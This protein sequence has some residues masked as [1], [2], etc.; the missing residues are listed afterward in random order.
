MYPIRRL[1]AALLL[2]LPLI[3]SADD[4]RVAV[5]ANFTAP[6]QRIAAAF[7][8][9]TGHRAVL[10]FGATGKFYAQ[11]H[12]GAP[13]TCCCP[14]MT[15]PR[16]GW[17]T[18]ASAWPAAASPTPSAPWC[19][20]RPARGTSTRKARSWP[21]AISVTWP[22]PIQ[23]RLPMALRQW[24]RWTGWACARNCGHASCR[25]RTLRKPTSSSPAAMPSSVSWRCRR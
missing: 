25:A 13:S 11:I 2:C 7:A 14:P 5:A 1:C 24:P 21:A 19:C 23:R 6:M 4:V 16:C 3:A 20:G 17:S 9:D 12:N 15:A 22:W 8:R 18:T 10:A